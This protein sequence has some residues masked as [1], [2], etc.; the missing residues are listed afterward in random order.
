MASDAERGVF[1]FPEPSIAE[2]LMRARD[3]VSAQPLRYQPPILS[4]ESAVLYERILRGEPSS[5]E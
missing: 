2:L 5:K 1:H 4:A 3:M